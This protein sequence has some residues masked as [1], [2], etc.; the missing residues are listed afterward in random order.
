MRPL[1]TLTVIAAL[2]LTGCATGKNPADPLESFNRGVYRFNDG[3]DKAVAK[4]VAQAYD[5]V[6]PNVG[7]IMVGNFFSNLDDVIVTFNDVLQLKFKQA[8]SDGTRVIFN[9][10]VGVF[11]LIEIT[12]RLEKHDEDF[13]QTL[14]YWGVGPG[15]YLMLPILGPSSLRDGTGLL[16]DSVPG[17]LGK[18]TPVATRNSLY[19][20]KATN[21]RAQLLESE[22]VM[23]EAVLDRYEFMRNAYLLRR[24]SLVYDGDPPRQ[25]YDDEGDDMGDP[26]MPAEDI[27]AQPEQPAQP[28]QPAQTAQPAQ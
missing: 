17:Q 25:K 1:R 21:R 23:D 24:E 20:V 19:V 26:G 12:T 8:F 22:K 10:T 2:T 3:L 11:G 14:G 7:K 15:P 6:M 16:V 9:S 28:A 27:K 18:I 13:G 5:K 4:P